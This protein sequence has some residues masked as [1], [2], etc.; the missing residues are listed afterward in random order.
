[1]NLQQIRDLYA[2]VQQALCRQW[3]LATYVFAAAAF[4]AL[5][6]T[7]LMPRSYYSEARLYI[8]FGRDHQIDP[9]ATGGQMISVYETRENEIN[10]LIEIFKSRAILDRV[11][12]ELGPQFVLSGRPKPANGQ[13]A[14]QSS[15]VLL[16][17][18]EKG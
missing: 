5:V 18:G 7:L 17:Q 1:M 16:L 15:P 6:G 8:K 11:V 12:E 9:I 13:N 2:F 3:R 10:S 14:S 4:I